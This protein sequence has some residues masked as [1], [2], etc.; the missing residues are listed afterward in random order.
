MI[1]QIPN[2]FL[3]YQ[4]IYWGNKILGKLILHTSVAV[5]SRSFEGLL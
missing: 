2:L 3:Q 4:K 5:Q 1:L